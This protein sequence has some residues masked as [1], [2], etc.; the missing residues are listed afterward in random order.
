[1]SGKPEVR[2]T[3]GVG[4]RI[5]TPPPSRPDASVDQRPAQASRY[6]HRSG[7]SRVS[8][9]LSPA[10]HIDV[11][12]NVKD[13]AKRIATEEILM[14]RKDSSFVSLHKLSK[15][16]NVIATKVSPR[17]AMTHDDIKKIVLKVDEELE[18]SSVSAVIPP[19]D[20]SSGPMPEVIVEA[21]ELAIYL[22]RAN[23]GVFFGEEYAYPTE[24]FPEKD[25]RLD[26]DGVMRLLGRRTL[27]YDE[28]EI[29]RIMTGATYDDDLGIHLPGEGQPAYRHVVPAPDYT[30]MAGQ[31][32]KYP[33][34]EWVEIIDGKRY[35]VFKHSW[36]DADGLEKMYEQRDLTR[37]YRNKTDTVLLWNE[38]DSEIIHPGPIP[39]FDDT[40]GGE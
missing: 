37:V 6:A 40:D 24:E 28:R 27:N 32:L 17:S 10:D 14:I 39:V 31:P 1:M 33:K 35:I 11:V 9:A 13:E 18:N 25:G 5:D 38:K 2:K 3:K 26:I 23:V 16:A 12:Q 4:K 22:N 15:I 34:K 19:V 29:R 8:H 7:T 30:N 20:E 36:I 21:K